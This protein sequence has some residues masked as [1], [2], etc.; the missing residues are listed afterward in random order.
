MGLGGWDT[1]RLADKLTVCVDFAA[2]WH[3]VTAHAQVPRWHTRSDSRYSECALRTRLHEAANA[4]MRGSKR[5]RLHIY[6]QMCPSH[7]MG[8]SQPRWLW[9]TDVYMYHVQCHRL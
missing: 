1:S 9:F 8:C 7:L 6:T 2:H 4:F 5:D 3:G